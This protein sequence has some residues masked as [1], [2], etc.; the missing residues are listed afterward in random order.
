MASPKITFYTNHRCPWAH[1]AHIVIKELGLPYE[2]VIIDLDKP[3]EPWYLEVN[4]RGLVPAIKISDGSLNDEIITESGI[5]AQFLADAY[6]SHL[7]PASGD[8]KSALKRA[9]IN[10]FVDTWFSKAGS[11]WFQIAQKDT[12][13]EKEAL[14]KDFVSIVAK[15]IE[16]LLKDAA[17]FFGGS[18]KLTLA[19]ALTAPF[20]LRIYTFAKHGILPESVLTGLNALPNFA[21]WA[22]EVIKHESVTYIFNEDKV[23]EGALKRFPSLKA[24]K[25]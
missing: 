24:Q 2:E 5:V 13:E 9:R 3:R 16:P 11:H 21:K 25:K 22:A 19:E 4:P 20:I 10:F 12:Q 18:E 8:P 17:P 6:P 14:A 23:I 7:V 1:R 15:E